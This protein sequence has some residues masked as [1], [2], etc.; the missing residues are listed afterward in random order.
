MKT[1]F[2]NVA[3][4]AAVGFCLSAPTET[5]AVVIYNSESSFR[6]AAAIES[7]ENFDA[8]TTDDGF[9][10]PVI[11]LDG[12][13]YSTTSCTNR[14][15]GFGIN[16]VSPPMSL[17]SDSLASDTLS[18]G[19]GRYV[20]SLGFWWG[21]LS[22]W[23]GGSF[24][25]W[26]IIVNE[27]NGS[28]T[29]IA[30][31]QG[32]ANTHYFGFTSESGIDNVVVRDNPLDSGATNWWYDDV[33]R[34]AIIG[35]DPVTDSIPVPSPALGG[36]D[37]WIGVV[38]EPGTYALFA[39]GLLMLAFRVKRRPGGNAPFLVNDAVSPP[40]G[41]VLASRKNSMLNKR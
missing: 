38:P 12:V 26:Q 19:S 20:N 25:G 29:V 16:H 36:P 37:Y 17:S 35:G 22:G 40:Y 8:Y 13:S 30:I 9:V 11:A 33:A 18:F 41:S 32:S 27:K 5:Q 2:L 39:A 23:V 24:L 10:T 31:P 1:G 7:T 28:S 4:A 15:W 6:S 21:G 34:G 14:C 3:C